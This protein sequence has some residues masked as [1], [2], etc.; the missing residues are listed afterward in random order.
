ME[1][2][3]QD[4]LDI[5][6]LDGVDA[7]LG[8]CEGGHNGV[9]VSI[10]AVDTAEMAFKE[11]AADR[12]FVDFVFAVEAPGHGEGVCG[13]WYSEAGVGAAK[14]LEALFL[15]DDTDEAVKVMKGC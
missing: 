7:L 2:R 11:I 13:V 14:G 4:G 12:G 3:S 8:M 5:G 6:R 10:A 9:R 15:E 1:P